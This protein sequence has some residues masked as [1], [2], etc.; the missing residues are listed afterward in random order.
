[1]KALRFLHVATLTCTTVYAAH[2]QETLA[3]ATNSGVDVPGHNH[4]YFT[5]VAPDKQLWLVR[6]LSVLPDP[7][8]QY[9]HQFIF[10]SGYIRDNLPGL[11]DATLEV[12]GVCPHY[13]TSGPGKITD[14][15]HL[16]V[17]H[18]GDKYGGPLKGV[19]NELLWDMVIWWPQYPREPPYEWEC[20][21]EAT[22]RLPDERILFSFAQNFTIKWAR[23]VKRH[24][25]QGVFQSETLSAP[26]SFPAV[27]QKMRPSKGNTVVSILCWSSALAR[28]S[29]EI[30]VNIVDPKVDVPGHNHAYYT[31]VPRE[32]QL[33]R[34]QELAV[35]P[36]PPVQNEHHFLYVS[37]YNAPNLPGLED[38]TLELS[39]V[40][41]EYYEQGPAKLADMY[42]LVRRTGEEYGG[43][44]RG[45]ENE[46]LWDMFVGA[47]PPHEPPFEYN[48]SLEATARLPDGRIFFSFAQNFTVK[49]PCYP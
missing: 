9:D 1:M 24:P 25:P 47:W 46:L 41:P 6:E 36:D 30:L 26:P 18:P 7:P 2:S 14:W 39:G 4:A 21:F 48:C 31:K 17:R 11:E 19:E 15:R 12:S 32:E 29:Q 23:A 42:H 33:F 34:V 38:T 37:G 3:D 22:T 49:W 40:C 45:D 13:W 35:H 20:S 44:L 27:G 43:P 8:V 28:A 10:V 16:V 5:K